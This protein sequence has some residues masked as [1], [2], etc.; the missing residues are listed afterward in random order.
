MPRQSVF[1]A[2]EP[3]VGRV[4]NETQC[5]HQLPQAAAT[6]NLEGEH[7]NWRQSHADDDWRVGLVS[8]DAAD[9]A[10]E[11]LIYLQARVGDFRHAQRDL[12][13]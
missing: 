1:V 7:E 11:G 12:R 3:A 4:H 5:E 2:R 6:V 8:A 13:F 10:G 9:Y